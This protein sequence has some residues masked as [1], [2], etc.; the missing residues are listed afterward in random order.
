MMTHKLTIPIPEETI[1]TLH[2]GDTAR[3]SGVIVTA[4]DVAHKYLVET[5]IKSDS[6]P[7]SE[8]PLYEE[9]KLLNG[10][11]TYHYGPVVRRSLPSPQH[12]WNTSAT[13]TF[14]RH[15]SKEAFCGIIRFRETDNERK[16]SIAAEAATALPHNCLPQLV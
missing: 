6:I 8:H 9:L 10:G 4:R 13:L 11:V 1:H 14:S 16:R 3:L 5:F 12:P 2:I 7:A 15:W